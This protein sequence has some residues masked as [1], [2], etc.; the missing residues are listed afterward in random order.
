MADPAPLCYVEIPAPDLEAA[1]AF[2][3]TVLGWRIEQGI[4]GTR[5]LSFDAGRLGGGFDPTLEPTDRGPLLYV[6]VSDVSAALEA[7]ARAG[8]GVVRGK[9]EIGGGHGF[10]AL[11]DDPNG[12]RMGLVSGS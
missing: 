3:G 6:Q 1:R 8:G 9:T 7:I 12:N 2:Y 10:S 5:Y 4:P 11:F